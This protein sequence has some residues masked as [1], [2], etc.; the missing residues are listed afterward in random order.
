MKHCTYD[1]T[2]STTVAFVVSIAWNYFIKVTTL[3]EIASQKS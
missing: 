1:K 2:N 3:K